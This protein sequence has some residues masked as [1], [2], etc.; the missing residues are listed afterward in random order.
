MDALWIILAVVAVVAALS[1]G[2][3]GAAWALARRPAGTPNR[4]AVEQIT[5]A[6]A[7]ELALRQADMQT[8]A[9][10]TTSEQFL[11]FAEQRLQAESG[12]G[13]E[14]LK[15]RQQEF[16]AG[17]KRVDS[18]LKEM[19][20]FVQRVDRARSESLVEL[21]TVVKQSQRSVELLNVNTAQ[22]NQALSSGQ[23]RG[24]WGE[25]MA[26]DI[27]QL[28][29]LIEGINYE[30][31]KQTTEEGTRPDFTFRL[32]QGR[33]VHMDVK[34]PLAGY[35]RLQ[36]AT[37]E[38]EQ[39]AAEKQFLQDA[40]QRIKEVTTRGYVDPGAGTLEF[41][42]VFIP[43]EQVFAFLQAK[44]PKMAD[45]ALRQQVVLCSP[46]TLFAVL[47]VI[48]QSTEHFRM[49]QHATE[50]L[51]AL[52]AFHKQWDLFVKA[53]DTVGK[54]LESTQQ[55]YSDL[56]STRT[57]QVDRSLRR[58]DE[59]RRQAGLPEGDAPAALPDVTSAAAEADEDDRLP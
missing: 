19:T 26:D 29:G 42:L 56:R 17:I 27:L 31:N 12:R 50:I 38:A 16:D 55:A 30:K 45:E 9:L 32:P 58:I 1:V 37:S 49:T 36:D 39:Q 33:V 34:F 48:R 15:A 25:R 2:A 23:A 22:L 47:A 7:A 46:L 6:I 3:G 43:N 4:D 35:L 18:T 28:A 8:R 5:A 13:E 51:S 10:Q 24:Q 44:D 53:M 54:R 52:N 21:A 40:R 41:M 11:Q 14:Q 59:L 20:E 57:N